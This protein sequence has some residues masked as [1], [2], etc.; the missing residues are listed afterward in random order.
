[1]TH[2]SRL[3]EEVVWWSHPA[4]GFVRPDDAFSTGSSMM[5]NKRNPDPAELIRGRTARVGGHVA[6]MLALLKGLPG[7][8]QRDLQEDKAPLFDALA[9]TESSLRV[10]AGLVGTLHVDE[11]RMRAAAAAGHTTATAVA[12]TLVELGVPFRAAHHVVGTLVARAEAAGAGLDTLTDRDIAEALAASADGSASGLTSDPAVAD[13][14]RAAAGLESALARPDVIG[15]TAPGR[16]AA[17]LTTA[18]E[19]LGLD[20]TAP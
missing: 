2:L 3:A 18:T 12:D 9:V 10:M 15:G 4:F 14:L 20:S 16:V 1:M 11:G 5:P 13:R 8:Y 6:A 17:E 19:R 7:G